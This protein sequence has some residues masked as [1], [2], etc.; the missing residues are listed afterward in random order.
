MALEAFGGLQIKRLFYYP[1]SLRGSTILGDGLRYLRTDKMRSGH[2]RRRLNSLPLAHDEFV[3]PGLAYDHALIRRLCADDDTIS[4]LIE[5]EQLSTGVMAIALGIA[6]G[7]YRSIIVSGFS[8]EI[9][10]AYARNPQIEEMGITNS[11][12][13]E[14]DIAVLS[15]LAR[16]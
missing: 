1:R 3:V 11:Q 13:A 14:I 16:E 7:A 15:H 5:A 9:T 8:F 12:H 6:A 2:F 4:R 10:Y